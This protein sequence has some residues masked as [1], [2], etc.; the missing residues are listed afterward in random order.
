MAIYTLRTTSGREDIVADMMLSKIRAEHLEVKAIV[1]PAELK[2]YIFIEGKIGDIHKATHSMLHIRG[3]MER[4]VKMEEIQHFLD[5][6]KAKIAVDKDDIVEIIGGPFKGERGKIQRID[7]AK[8]EVTVELLEASVP[9]PVTIATEFVKLVKRAK[10]RKKEEA[11]PTGEQARREEGPQ[12]GK[13]LGEAGLPGAEEI[14]K[15]LTEKPEEKR[16]EEKPAEE[17]PAEE[18]AKEEEKAEEEE[19]SILEEAQKR[20][21]KELEAH[22]TPEEAEKPAEPVKPEERKEK[23]P[24]EKKVIKP[25]E[26]VIMESEEELEKPVIPQEPEEKSSGEPARKEKGPQ[27]GEA[28]EE[29]DS[30]LSDLEKEKK[31][32]KSPEDLEE[33]E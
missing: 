9:I 27:G 26:P 1:H 33:G 8:D 2:G 22:E 3:L 10:G 25:E 24:E 28:L 32:K 20:A 14:R 21:E 4:P 16:P 6:T 29:E 7:K 17:A 13:A 12:G 18:P 15:G 30:I 23:P 11:R 5:T 31:K 19:P